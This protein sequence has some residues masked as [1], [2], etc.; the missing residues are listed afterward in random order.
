VAV[1][2][3]CTDGQSCFDQVT[4]DAATTAIGDLVFGECGQETSGRPPLLVGLLSELGPH[5][6]DGGQ[7]QVGE[8]QLDARGID[9]VGHLHATP[10]SSTGSMFGARTTASSS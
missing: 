3:C 8:Q 5:Q 2:D 9:R 1:G 6:L 10:P 4:F 7:A